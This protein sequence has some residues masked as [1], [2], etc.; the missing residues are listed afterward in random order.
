MVYIY[1]STI[2]VLIAGEG[3]SSSSGLE[4]STISFPFIGSLTPDVPPGGYCKGFNVRHQLLTDHSPSARS[5][6]S[7]KG[8]KVVIPPTRSL[9]APD[10]ASEPGRLPNGY[11][12]LL[13]A[14]SSLRQTLLEDNTL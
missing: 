3:E 5:L 7:L 14:I 13:E 2:C 9:P 11:S 12:E 8:Q 6:A 4:S 1:R 10:L